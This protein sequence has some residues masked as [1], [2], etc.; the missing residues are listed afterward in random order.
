MLDLITQ[1]KTRLASLMEDQLFDV[2]IGGT[3]SIRILQLGITSKALGEPPFVVIRLRS[4]SDEH[5]SSTISLELIGNIYVN[6]DRDSDGE[7]DTDEALIA[8]AMAD[9][10]KLIVGYRSLLADGNYYPYSMESMKYWVGDKNDG[11]HPGPDY[12]EV[13]AEL[14]FQQSPIA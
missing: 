12:Y 6:P 14:V 13:S 7:T 5:M 4:G 9:M 8:A 11:Q 3:S 1:V 10:K 2:E